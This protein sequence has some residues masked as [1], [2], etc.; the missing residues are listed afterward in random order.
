MWDLHA[1]GLQPSPG[2]RFPLHP[3]YAIRL[4]HC[5]ACKSHLQATLQYR[6]VS[7]PFAMG[8][9]QQLHLISSLR[10]AKPCPQCRRGIAGPAPHPSSSQPPPP[11]CPP[12]GQVGR[13]R[14]R[15][16]RWDSPRISAF[17]P[18]SSRVSHLHGEVSFQ[19]S[20]RSRRRGCQ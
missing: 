7:P 16:A 19:L 3:V 17:T 10:A 8:W 12:R 1:Q 5:T 13:R 2:H 20:V 6:G 4:P 15:R 9:S 11:A 18:G 14:R